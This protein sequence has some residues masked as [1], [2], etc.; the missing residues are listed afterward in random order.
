MHMKHNLLANILNNSTEI[1]GDKGYW[2]SNFGKHGVTQSIDS[3]LEIETSVY[4]LISLIQI[5]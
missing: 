3:G 2:M 1:G 5:Q 4:N